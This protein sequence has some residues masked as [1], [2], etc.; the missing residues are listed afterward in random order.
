MGPQKAEACAGA[1]HQGRL[2][3]DL[4]VGNVSVAKIDPVGLLPLDQAGQL[5]LVEY[6]DAEG[7]QRSAK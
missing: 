7:V 5:R 2:V 3:H 4:L 6:G 1:Q